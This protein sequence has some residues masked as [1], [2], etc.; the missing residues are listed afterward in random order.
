MI[1]GNTTTHVTLKKSDITLR[2]A[3]MGQSV[4]VLA[5][6]F[7]LSKS[8]MTR[9]L[10]E[11]NL[12]KSR[13]HEEITESKSKI[14]LASETHGVSIDIIKKIIVDCGYKLPVRRSKNYTIIDDV[15]EHIEE[16]KT[17]EDSVQTDTTN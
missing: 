6:N 5:D 13:T 11:M 15:S 4:E 14:E 16:I 9:A 3:A 17:K 2:F 10:K 7:G 1:E 8:E 12:I